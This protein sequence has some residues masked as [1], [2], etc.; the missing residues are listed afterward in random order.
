MKEYIVIFASDKTL[1]RGDSTLIFIFLLRGFFGLVLDLINICPQLF[2]FIF[3][4]DFSSKLKENLINK[5]INSST[6]SK[7]KRVILK[8]FP[9]ILKKLIKP[10]AIE[11]I[12]WHKNKGHRILIVSDL[13]KPIIL[14]LSNY[15]DVEI[16]ATECNDILKINSSEKFV[17]KTSN[18][19]GAE[20]LI[21]LRDYLGYIP[22]SNY[23][24]VYGD[25]KGD[26]E[27]LDASSYPHFRSFKNKPNKFRENNYE[28]NIFIIIAIF[29]FI[30]G[31][32]KLLDLDILQVADL[33]S[34]FSKLIS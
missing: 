2:K 15:F 29:I 27:L 22:D 12:K 34:S 20:K 25:S 24:E 10:A 3:E 5:A 32:N 9:K 7:R 14:S 6:V 21:R 4:R 33:K 8:Q 16:I 19:K 30:L 18:R 23:F 26:K 11:R 31:T 1:I 17:F 28:S 13:P